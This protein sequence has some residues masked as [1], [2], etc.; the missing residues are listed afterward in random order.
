MRPAMDCTEVR[1]K[2]HAFLDAECAPDEREAVRE[3]LRRCAD[4]RREADELTGLEARLRRELASEQA[5]ANLWNRIAARLDGE[6]HGASTRKASA[7]SP[8]RWL[9][10]GLGAAALGLAAMLAVVLLP[11]TLPTAEL[12]VV[13]EPVNDFITY[14]L[15]GRA[16]DISSADPGELGDWLAGRIDFPLRVPAHRPAGFGL[17]G[18][19]LCS[20]LNRRLTALMYQKD[21][22]GLSLYVMAADRLELPEARWVPAAGRQLSRHRV[23]GHASLVWR[24]GGLVYALVSDLPEA[25]LL[26]FVAELQATPRQP[27]A[28]GLKAG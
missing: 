8:R 1:D 22:A 25:E 24:E 27:E 20:F 17:T 28:A 19:R 6:E 7:R 12:P 5:P 15:S 18:S 13:V 23:Q 10:S 3:H 26:R 9:R 11:V 14:K 4:C 16:P 21:D 2:L